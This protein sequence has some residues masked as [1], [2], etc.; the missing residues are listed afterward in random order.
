MDRDPFLEQ[1]LDTPIP[2][3]ALATAANFTAREEGDRLLFEA[4]KVFYGLYG[5]R[6]PHADRVTMRMLLEDPSLACLGESDDQPRVLRYKIIWLMVRYAVNSIALDTNRT[7]EAVMK[8]EHPQESLE[9]LV[10]I[11]SNARTMPPSAV[12]PHQS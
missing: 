10:S 2:T 6:D 8:D 9:E 3:L 5:N 12:T 1:L 7:I 4:S 11:I